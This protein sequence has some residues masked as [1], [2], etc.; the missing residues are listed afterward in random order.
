[1]RKERTK[2]DKAWSIPAGRW[3]SSYRAE[4]E[5]FLV[6]VKDATSAP[7]DVKTIRFSTD[8][9]SLVM[10]RR[11]RPSRAAPETLTEIWNCLT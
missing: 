7:R 10:F 3:T 8:S 11:T 4:Q 2:G 9:L 5:A 6:A 1:M